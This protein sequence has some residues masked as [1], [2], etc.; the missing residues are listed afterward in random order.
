[1][2]IT[3]YLLATAALIFSSCSKGPTYA[4]I[5]TS[6][7]DIVVMLYEDTPRHSKNFAKLAEEEF[8]DGTLFHR[9][10]PGFMIQGG[11]PDS[12]DAKPGQMLGQGNPG[13]TI[14]EE[15]GKP[16][17]RGALAAARGPNPQRASSGSQFY[18][19]TGQRQTDASL[20]NWEQ[21]HNIVYNEVQ[22][23]RYKNFGGRPDL[24]MEYTVFGEVIEGIEVADAIAQATRD[25]NNRPRQDIS[26][27]V[28]IL[29][30]YTP[31]GGE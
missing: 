31:A 27:E 24:D 28:T 13:Y 18:I 21:R 9:V 15:I 7:G 8:Y 25:N 4:R 17:L 12:R 10:I 19:V 16:H 1:M 11:D 20:D 26:M 6:L 30:G 5:S 29:D 14:E 22:R 3:L 2:R 23:E